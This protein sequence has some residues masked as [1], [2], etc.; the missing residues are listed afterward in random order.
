MIQARQEQRIVAS[1]DERTVTVVLRPSKNLAF[2]MIVGALSVP[3]AVMV[4]GFVAC[5]VRQAF[6]TGAPDAVIAAVMFGVVGGAMLAVNLLV[7]RCNL[8]G[9]IQMKVEPDELK[10][11]R[12]FYPLG[13][14]ET[15]LRKH[16]GRF[17]VWRPLESRN[18][19]RFDY[20]IWGVGPW[21]LGLGGAVDPHP[22]MIRLTR[23]EVR[24]VAEALRAAGYTVES[25]D[26]AWVST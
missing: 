14:S 24:C 5:C 9:E 11:S 6:L 8:K 1:I 17:W 23:A 21:W 25:N 18:L 26:K 20:Q 12:R 10:C 4:V 13:T 7:L 16:G 2:T 19:G 15:I 22:L 3:L